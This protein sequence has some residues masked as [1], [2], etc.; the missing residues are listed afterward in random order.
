MRWFARTEQLLGEAAYARLASS[1]VAVFGLG[2]VGSYAVEAL[3]RAGVGELR[4]VD[5]GVVDE[6]NIN[7]QLFALHSTVGQRKVDLA[8]ARV[9]DIQPECRVDV[10]PGFVNAETVEG[11]LDPAPDLVI[12]A[13]DSL[14]SKVTLLET[15]WRRGLPLVSSMGAGGR[16]DMGALRVGD[17]AET[18]ICP[19]AR[20]VRLRL[21]RRGVTGGIPCVYSVEPARNT[22][23]YQAQ[24]RGEHFGTG[25][26]RTPIGTVSYMPAAFG[27]R[28]A[29][30]AIA[31]LLAVAPE[32][33]TQKQVEMA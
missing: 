25:R 28:V 32:G 14:N 33:E 2:G 13:I 4:L 1:R 27:L 22:T 7:R 16:L 6:S 19:L 3:A 24:D 10:R 5:Y 11:F 31:R 23:P 15:V 29:Q 17:L 18:T 8:A 21:R 9:R 30:E 12:D 20:M 26:V